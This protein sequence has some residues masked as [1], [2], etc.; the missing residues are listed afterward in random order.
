MPKQLTEDSTQLP[1]AA[2]V[3]QAFIQLPVRMMSTPYRYRPVSTGMRAQD[4]GILV[5]ETVVLK[6]QRLDSII[7]QRTQPPNVIITRP[8]T[9]PQYYRLVLSE[10]ERSHLWVMEVSPLLAGTHCTQGLLSPPASKSNIECSTSPSLY[11]QVVGAATVVD[12]CTGTVGPV[13]TDP[14]I[15][16]A[17][18]QLSTWRP[19]PQGQ[20]AYDNFTIGEIWTDWSSIVAVGDV[21]YHFPLEVKDLE[22]PTWGLGRSTLADGTVTTTIGPPFLPL[23]KPMMQ[24]FTL[25][26][27]WSAACTG[28]LTDAFAGLTFEIFDPPMA[29]TPGVGL[30]P[31]PN[32]NSATTPHPSDAGPTT[33][34][35]PQVPRP[36]ETANPASSPVLAPALPTNSESPAE[37]SVGVPLSPS[38][39]EPTKS[40]D[41][42]L[43][44]TV[45]PQGTSVADPDAQSP[46]SAQASARTQ[47]ADPDVPAPVDPNTMLEDPQGPVVSATASAEPAEQKGDGSAQ[48]TQDVG[49]IIYNALGRSE[50]GAT[51]SHNNINTLTIPSTGDQDVDVPGS[52]Q[53]ISIQPSNIVLDGTTYSAGGPVMT[54]SDSVF[55]IVPQPEPVYSASAANNDPKN[56]IPLNSDPLT[57]AGKPVVINPSTPNPNNGIISPNDPVQTPAGTNIN[58]EQPVASATENSG[59]LLPA[60]VLR[61]ISATGNPVLAP[62]ISALSIAGTT[63]SAG[64]PA[65]TVSGTIISLQPSGTLVMGSSTVDLKTAGSGTALLPDPGAPS[66]DAYNVDG[67]SV[68]VQPQ[69][70]LAVVNGAALSDG[71]PGVTV[72]GS[73]V[74]LEPG[75]K[76]LDVGT[77]HFAVPTEAADASYDIDRFSIQA[78]PQSSIA[79]VNGVTLI[80]GESGVSISGSLVRLESGGKTLDVGT[81]RFPMPTEAADATYEVDGFSVQVHPQSSFAVIDGTTLGAGGPGITVSGS[82]VSLE[83]GGKTLD[84]G[85]ARFAMPTEAADG[86]SPYAIDGFTVQLLPQSSIAVVD[87]VTLT[88]GAPGIS[89][90]G[91][92]ISLESGGQTLDIGTSRFPLPTPSTLSSSPYDIDGY[93]IQPKPQPSSFAI[94]DG[95]TLSAGGPGTSI[96]GSLVSLESGGKTLDIGT[97]RFA[98]PTAAAGVGNVNGTASRVQAFMGGQRRRCEVSGV[99]MAGMVGLGCLMTA[100]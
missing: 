8:P 67:L 93:T 34:S 97:G 41:P 25:D 100:I 87:G 81:A 14:I 73:L 28:L 68:Q 94:V 36:T 32:Q 2:A 22:C 66:A 6:Y 54:L 98:M 5:A 44:D 3:I 12:K 33:T 90:S 70:S 51:D 1:I 62:A 63:I 17:P 72:S 37:N 65:I 11:L 85:T 78:Q 91:T 53:V 56:N 80:A 38:L 49:A 79:V 31:A 47:T 77:A 55:T 86:T 92:R 64:G 39:P 75:G 58:Q 50:G 59:A 61:P 95:V 48:Q 29:L 96:S 69:S 15:T 9:L 30:V 84:M 82:L 13:L 4:G 74:S 16:F 20:W 46:S 99:L 24:V 42:P 57:I 19:P 21:G 60:V 45:L 88:A 43:D 83:P 23:I 71:G 27:S 76:T 52:N 26:P 18:G 40:L 35:D 89:I 10:K 7:S